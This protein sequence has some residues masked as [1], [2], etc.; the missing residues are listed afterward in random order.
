MAPADLLTASLALNAAQSHLLQKAVTHPDLMG[1]F[2]IMHERSKIRSVTKTFTAL[3][4]GG[5]K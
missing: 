1:K 5:V 2:K 4:I 3:A